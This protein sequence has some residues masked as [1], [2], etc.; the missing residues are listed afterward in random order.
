MTH[1]YVKQNF[2][3]FEDMTSSF[4][5]GLGLTLI[6]LIEKDVAA[7]ISK[8]LL[9]KEFARVNQTFQ[10]FVKASKHSLR[11]MNFMPHHY[12]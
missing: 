5:Y 10:G 8:N 12:F 3:D 11:K 9:N 1:P 7:Q 4:F 2:L 6:N